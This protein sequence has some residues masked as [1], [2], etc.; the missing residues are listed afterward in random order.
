MSNIETVI[1]TSPVIPVLVIDDVTVAEPLARALVQGGLC[2]LEVTLRTPAA[3]E[4]IKRMKCVEGALVGAGTILGAADA[5][6]AVEAGASFLVSPGLIGSLLPASQEL[7]V[8]LLP[9]VA[10]A[11]EVMRGLEQGLT[12]FKFFPAE[13]AGGLA[14]LR[15]FAGPFPQVGFCPTGGIDTSN[16]K[17]YLALPNVACAGGSWVA[18]RSLVSTRDWA[19]I[20]ALARASSCLAKERP[21]SGRAV[22][23]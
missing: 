16:V 6:R 23:Q 17:D 10:T 21:L 1:G 14:M 11:T 15:S 3:L 22:D 2:V 20:T 19:A 13:A 18:P 12:A 7:G 9:G 8:P 5:N 4:A